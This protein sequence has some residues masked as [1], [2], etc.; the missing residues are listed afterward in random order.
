MVK[1]GTFPVN[2]T[3]VLCS[4]TQNWETMLKSDWQWAG[5][6]WLSP[7]SKLYCGRLRKELGKN[8]EAESS[9]E[10]RVLVCRTFP[11]VLS[12]APSSSQSRVGRGFR[13]RSGKLDVWL[14]NFRRERCW[15]VAQPEKVSTWAAGWSSLW[16]QN[17][18][19]TTVEW[20][21]LRHC[22]AKVL[23][24][25]GPDVESGGQRRPCTILQ[26]SLGHEASCLGVR[27]ALQK[28]CTISCRSHGASLEGVS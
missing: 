6:S 3:L 20:A 17:R 5:Q 2:L 18:D 26:K 7:S 10:I 27:W 16:W 22:G 23:V 19:R 14:M 8:G 12:S 4:L 28:V 13:Q 1:I 21:P 25:C 11:P 9:L 15:D 24:F